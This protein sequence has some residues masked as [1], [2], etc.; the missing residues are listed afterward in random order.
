M[1]ST[2]KSSGKIFSAFPDTNIWEL[3]L[4]RCLSVDQEHSPRASTVTKNILRENLEL[5]QKVTNVT[6]RRVG[7]ET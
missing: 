1:G 6:K 2:A 7:D 3:L 5:E 4:G